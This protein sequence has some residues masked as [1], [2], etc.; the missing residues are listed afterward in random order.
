MT[1]KEQE[2]LTRVAQTAP[3]STAALP[4]SGNE[5]PSHTPG[6]WVAEQSI[7]YA[8]RFRAIVELEIDGQKKQH[9]EG[10]LAL[11]YAP[12]QGDYVCRHDSNAR[13]IAASPDLLAALKAL[14]SAARWCPEAIEVV[15]DANLAIAKAE[16]R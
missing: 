12:R 16:G 7:V 15:I 13:L 3:A 5:L 6:P 1:H 4:Q 11:V 2:D 10:L 8:E 9:D 14:V